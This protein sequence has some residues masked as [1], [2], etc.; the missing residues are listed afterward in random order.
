MSAP[1]PQPTS[2]NMFQAREMP[3]YMG[4][5]LLGFKVLKT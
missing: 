3:I 1:N 5:N 4:S 2:L